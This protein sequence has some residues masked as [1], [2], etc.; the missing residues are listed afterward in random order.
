[1]V[2][3]YLAK[4][5]F[6]HEKISKKEIEKRYGKNFNY[7]LANLLYAR[8]FL[9]KED[10][11][12]FLNPKWEDNHDP[13]L[14]SE[15][16]KAVKR[17]WKAVE[18][19]ENILIFADYDT[20][21]I[22]GAALFYD[23]FRK[24]NYDFVKVLIPDRNFDGYGLSLKMA[25]KI[26]GG[27]DDDNFKADLVITVDC[28]INDFEGAEFLN[29]KKIDLII[30]DHHLFAEKKPEALAIIN[31]KEEGGDYPEKNLCGAGVVFKLVQAL[32][33]EKKD[34]ELKEGWEK[35]LLD[36]VSISTVCDM[37]PL[38]GENRLFVKY[39]QVVFKNTHRK[40]LN[41]IIEK[42]R[43]N[44]KNITVDDL[45]FMIGPRINAASRLDNPV[46][47]FKSLTLFDEGSIESAEFLEK[48]NNKRKYLL[49]KIMKEVYKKLREREIKEVIVLGNSDWPLGLLGL[50]A[51]RV[52]DKY[53]RP[54]FV[55]TE[56]IKDNKKI[57]K[58]SC[59][60][61]SEY[62]LY[63]LMEKNSDIFLSFGGHHL[64]G[65]FSLE[66][67][68]IF[69]LEEKLS[70][71]IRKNLIKKVEKEPVII[72]AE[73]SLSDVNLENYYQIEKLEP[74][75]VGNQK[76]L[77]FFRSLKINKV[78]YF[79]KDKNHLELEFRKNNYEY[80]KAILFNFEDKIDESLDL[81]D[82]DKINLIASIE[83]EEWRS[84]KKL[85]LFI[86]DIFK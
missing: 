25:E 46:V 4:N 19:K 62:S 43:L 57:I 83:L 41:K 17:I 11:E 61:G 9:N 81:K 55:W 44:K 71:K 22:P 53:K 31:P 23:F 75:G 47:A 39:G 27:L 86:K 33:K 10:A 79:G 26:A 35:W 5:Y 45:G 74:Y 73:I 14:F 32:I 6:L 69:L 21:G 15:M 56:F 68:N 85:R 8:G 77:F 36:L 58:G 80:I 78:R 84:W 70:E 2:E 51:G 34:L 72:D 30:T 38:K 50:I 1:M 12:N 66:K 59:R 24:I 65:G 49:S 60:S 52:A 76:P 13:F 28:G 54:T 16:G 64:S 18:K 63:S 48:L 40:G 7:L 37:V 67:E 42:S 20:D 82:G 3:K 29:K